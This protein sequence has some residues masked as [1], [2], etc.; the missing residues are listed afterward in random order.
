MIFTVNKKVLHRLLEGSREQRTFWIGH[1]S[2][3]RY[4]NVGFF[5][6]REILTEIKCNFFLSEI[7]THNNFASK[8]STET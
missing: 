6:K 5:Q 8:S 7:R 3:E 4:I 2:D 1:L